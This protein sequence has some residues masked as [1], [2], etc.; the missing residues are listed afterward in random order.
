MK[1]PM[2]IEP[3][4]QYLDGTPSYSL[5]FEQLDGAGLTA[6]TIDPTLIAE[7]YAGLERRMT[8]EIQQTCSQTDFC[9]GSGL[10]TLVR[11]Q[12]IAASICCRAMMCPRVQAGATHYTTDPE[13]A[14]VANY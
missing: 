9:E 4:G 10:P 7:S 1:I 11:G 2:S 8:T 14:P 5:S 12:L 3:F 6:V 13:A